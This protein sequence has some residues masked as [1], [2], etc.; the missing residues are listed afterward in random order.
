MIKKG[1]MICSK[2]K[3][4]VINELSMVYQNL[5]RKVK[6]DKERYLHYLFE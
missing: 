4:K 5:I 1:E 6:R 2:N 3:G